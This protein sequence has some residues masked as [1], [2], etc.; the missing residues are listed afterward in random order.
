MMDLDD[1][2]YIKP[3]TPTRRAKI[4]EGF[5]NAINELRGCEQNSFVRTQISV[6]LTYKRL[7]H[8]LPDGY[9]LPFREN[10]LSVSPS[11]LLTQFFER[12]KG[13]EK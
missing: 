5:D 7:I 9:P 11:I 13:K 10:Y 4:D 8:N 1:G 3:M 2:I 6:L 12:R